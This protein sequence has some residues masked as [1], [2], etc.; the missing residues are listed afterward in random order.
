MTY[1]WRLECIHL[2]MITS[3][4]YSK[5]L[6]RIHSSLA[7]QVLS[8]PAN[9]P[10]GPD[11]FCLSFVGQDQEK[12]GEGCGLKL[13]GGDTFLLGPE[14]G[15]GSEQGNKWGAEQEN[16]QELLKEGG[17]CDNL[18]PHAAREE[19]LNHLVATF[20]GEW[21][22]LQRRTTTSA[23]LTADDSPAREGRGQCCPVSLQLCRSVSET[24]LH[25]RLSILS[26]NLGP[27]PQGGRQFN[28][29]EANTAPLFFA[30]PQRRKNPPPPPPENCCLVKREEPTSRGPG[31]KGEW[32]EL[33]RHTPLPP[34]PRREH[35]G[36]GL[37][38]GGSAGSQ[39]P[40]HWALLRRAGHRRTLR[41][42]LSPGEGGHSGKREG[43]F[44]AS[45]SHQVK[46]HIHHPVTTEP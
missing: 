11:G 37:L 30:L 22:S 28:T 16:V 29:L 42:S 6:R 19:D 34:A 18:Q 45:T 23:L 35:E 26:L 2:R 14:A 25:T 31:G 15:K 27:S 39:G 5:L 32:A 4:R 36:A 8:I 10:P 33:R 21:G 38:P 20:I 7:P 41:E 3:S 1:L 46:D 12:E 43:S 9:I 40:Q 17:L 24:Q 13:A 44:R